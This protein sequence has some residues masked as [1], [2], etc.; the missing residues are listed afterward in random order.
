VPPVNFHCIRSNFARG[1]EVFDEQVLLQNQ[2]HAGGRSLRLKERSCRVRPLIPGP[3]RPHDSFHIDDRSYTIRMTLRPGK[4]ECGSPVVDDEDHISID[5]EFV[6]P[7]V[8]ISLVID[9][10]VA[11]VSGSTGIC[12]KMRQELPQV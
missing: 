2:L 8:Q 7:S 10:A 11:A 3:E 12:A 9:E 1:Q 6:K 5:S 4:S